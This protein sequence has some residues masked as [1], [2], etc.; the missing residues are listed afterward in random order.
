LNI[1]NVCCIY[2]DIPEEWRTAIVIPINKKG[3]RNNPDNCRGISLLNTRLK[4][5]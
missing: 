2:G 4:I 3:D 1:L 5:Y